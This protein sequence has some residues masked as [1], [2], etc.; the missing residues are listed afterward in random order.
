MTP[1][2]PSSYQDYIPSSHFTILVVQT[3]FVFGRIRILHRHEPE[4]VTQSLSFTQRPQVDRQT[5][6]NMT[7]NT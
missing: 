4:F 3:V 5:T 7:A 1:V 6:A 2:S